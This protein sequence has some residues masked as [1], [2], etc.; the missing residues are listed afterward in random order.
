MQNSLSTT[1]EHGFG[2]WATTVTLCFNDNK[3]L[4]DIRQDPFFGYLL[5]PRIII[6]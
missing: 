5:F 6:I 4:A 2:S 1:T 3:T